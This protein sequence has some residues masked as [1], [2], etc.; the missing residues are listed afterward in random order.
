MTVDEKP[1]DVELKEV[2]TEW[3]FVLKNGEFLNCYLIV[4]TTD[5]VIKFRFKRPF[6]FTK[7]LKLKFI[8]SSSPGLLIK[9]VDMEDNVGVRTDDGNVNLMQNQETNY[10]MFFNK[11]GKFGIENGQETGTLETKDWNGKKYVPF[12]VSLIGKDKDAQFELFFKKGTIAFDS[13]LQPVKPS[14]PAT[15]KA[16]MDIIF[17]VCGG[18]G[19]LVVLGAIAGGIY[20]YRKKKAKKHENTDEMHA[21]IKMT[22]EKKTGEIVMESAKGEATDKEAENKKE[23]TDQKS[24]IYDIDLITIVAEAGWIGLI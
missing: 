13:S 21:A 19:I 7:V 9:F 6:T 24:G 17:G 15:D 23:T 3:M 2:G 10:D 4:A 16:T 11:D 8:F 12:R 5:P 18:I 22:D 20:C 14:P 1:K